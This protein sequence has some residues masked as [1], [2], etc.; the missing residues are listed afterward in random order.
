MEQERVERRVGQVRRSFVRTFYTAILL[1]MIGT[2]QSCFGLTIISAWLSLTINIHTQLSPN[3]S[4]FWKGN[5]YY[6]SSH[7]F[8]WFLGENYAV[9][10]LYPPHIHRCIQYMTH[11]TQYMV[12]CSKQMAHCAQYMAQY[13]IHN[14]HCTHYSVSPLSS[15]SEPVKDSCDTQ[16]ASVQLIP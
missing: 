6:V 16:H 7:I 10:H 11:C 15:F 14:I 9:C 8:R 1:D 13:T 2:V 3:I 4:P 12:N 5:I